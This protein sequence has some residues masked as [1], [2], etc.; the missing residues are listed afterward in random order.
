[1]TQTMGS[2][3]GGSGGTVYTS[4]GNVTIGNKIPRS[5]DFDMEVLGHYVHASEGI[6]D[7][8]R[9]QTVWKLVANNHKYV[10]YRRVKSK[11]Q[12]RMG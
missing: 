3:G 11:F 9:D 2:G 10:I 4:R 5:W 1:M 8:P 7:V 12:G 6:I